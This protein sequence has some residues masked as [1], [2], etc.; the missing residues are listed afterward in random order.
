MDEF[1]LFIEDLAE[2]LTGGP[3]A[4]T[5]SALGEDG[6]Q[7]TTQALGEEGDAPDDPL[8]TTQA[9]GEE[10]DAPE[11]PFDPRLT[12]TH[13]D[14]EPADQGFGSG[15]APRSTLGSPPPTRTSNP[16]SAPART[17]R[18]TPTSPPRGTTSGLP[19]SR[20]RAPGSTS[21]ST[22]R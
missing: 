8:V 17:P 14:I 22:R 3:T 15:G 4:A 21:R 19:V 20:T 11:Q 10:G 1:R 2:T 16:A 7:T 13:E 18:S 12:T 5:T 6:G 9:L